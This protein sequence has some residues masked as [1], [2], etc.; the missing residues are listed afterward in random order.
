MAG[1]LSGT[2]KTRL[3]CL[4][5]LALG[6]HQTYVALTQGKHGYLVWSIPVVLIALLVFIVPNP[7][8]RRR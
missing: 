2:A 4:V 5:V 8:S 3:V 1:K 6:G 7:R